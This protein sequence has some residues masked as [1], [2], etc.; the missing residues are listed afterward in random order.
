MERDWTRLG[1]MLAAAREARAITQ[2]EMADRIGVKRNALW[3]LERGESKRVTGTHRAYARHVGWAAGSIERVLDGL[4]PVVGESP[5]DSPTQ[6]LDGSS[7]ENGPAYARGMPSR[8]AV[9]VANGDVYDTDIIDLST[10]SSAPLVMIAKDL[11][12][13]ATEEERRTYVRMWT[14]IQREVRQIVDDE[15]SNP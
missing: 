5:G 13:D 14:R 11:P 15:R 3:R 12:P 9:Q 6:G 2:Q 8:V 1:G 7:V 10:S 4:D